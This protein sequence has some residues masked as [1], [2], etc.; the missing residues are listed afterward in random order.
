MDLEIKNFGIKNFRSF[1]HDGVFIDNI[2]QIN[3]FIGKNNAGKSN[4]LKFIKTLSDNLIDLVEFPNDLI[5][6]HKRNVLD[7]ILYFSFNFSDDP[8]CLSSSTNLESST[9]AKIFD[10]F[11]T[12]IGRYCEVVNT[13]VRITDSIFYNK[14]KVNSILI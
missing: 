4:V 14:M 6:N 10:F 8:A 11:I 7:T 3:V 13:K 9:Y 2:N 5:N 1:D 12:L